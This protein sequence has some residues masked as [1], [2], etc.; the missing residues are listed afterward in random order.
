MSV[1]LLFDVELLPHF[2]NKD[3][4]SLKAA[5]KTGCESEVWLCRRVKMLWKYTEGIKSRVILFNYGVCL[6]QKIW[7]NFIN[8]SNFCRK[9]QF[10]QI[11][12]LIIIWTSWNY[13]FRNSA[14]EIISFIYFNLF[15]SILYNFIQLYSL[16]NCYIIMIYSSY[17]RHFVARKQY[18]FHL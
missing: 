11:Y 16:H 9:C 13:N 15:N 18:Y 6:L 3:S 8:Y 14:I 10:T 17:C 7:L 12:Q 1:R 2:S 4:R 5:V